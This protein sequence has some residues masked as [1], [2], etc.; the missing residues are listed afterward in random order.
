MH[1]ALG[2]NSENLDIARFLNV[3]PPLEQETHRTI[4]TQPSAAEEEAGTLSFHRTSRRNGEWVIGDQFNRRHPAW[5]AAAGFPPI[6]EPEDAPVILVFRIDGAYYARL[7]SA[8]RIAQL[9]TSIPKR[10]NGQKGVAEIE[11]ELIDRFGVNFNS[12]LAEFEKQARTEVTEFDPQNVIDGRARTYSSI[13]RRQ[14]QPL[15]RQRLL[16]AYGGRCAITGPSP[17]WVLEAAH[18]TPYRGVDTNVVGNGLLLRADVHTLFDLHLISVEPSNR[19]VRVSS[20]LDGS[21]YVPFHG[22][23]LAL[24]KKGMRPS[25][26]ALKEHYSKFRA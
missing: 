9:G 1:I 10:L 25:Q 22:Q 14:G 26:A 17:I 4:T 12:E 20:M 6:Y 8:R 7:S 21:E 11:P 18:I 3:A 24:A 15:F 13:I 23:P 16:T 19:L 2:V 5:S